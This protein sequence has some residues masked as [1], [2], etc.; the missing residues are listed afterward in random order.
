MPLGIKISLK[1]PNYHDYI[2]HRCTDKLIRSFHSFQE[3][4]VCTNISELI[5]FPSTG[6]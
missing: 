2:E 4:A 6:L 5:G 1:W 3:M